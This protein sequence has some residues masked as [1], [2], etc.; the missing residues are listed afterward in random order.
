MDA[1]LSQIDV[2]PLFLDRLCVFEIEIGEMHVKPQPVHFPDDSPAG[3]KNSM[4]KALLV[5]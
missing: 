1:A 2:H 4:R 5:P 3:C